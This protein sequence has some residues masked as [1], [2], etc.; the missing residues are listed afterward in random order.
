[1]LLPEWEYRKK[2]VVKMEKGTAWMEFSGIGSSENGNRYCL[3]GI[4]GNRQ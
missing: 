4:F 2:A 3:D 1:M